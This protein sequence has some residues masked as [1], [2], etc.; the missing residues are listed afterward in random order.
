VTETIGNP[1]ELD[2]QVR[3]LVAALDRATTILQ[4]QP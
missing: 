4:P 2:E 1:S 3:R